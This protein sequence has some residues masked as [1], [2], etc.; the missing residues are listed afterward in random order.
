MLAGCGSGQGGHSVRSASA[1]ARSAPAPAPS[2]ADV[3]SLIAAMAVHGAVCANVDLETGG[4]VTGEVNPYAECDGA[5][6]GDTAILVFTN[7]ADAVAYA[8]NMIRAGQITG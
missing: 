8:H 4:T 2:Y 1:A 6:S 5:T 7:H 3:E